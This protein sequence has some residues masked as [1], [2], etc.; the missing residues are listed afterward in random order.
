[1]TTGLDSVW[2]SVSMSTTTNKRRGLEVGREV[3]IAGVPGRF[4]VKALTETTVTCWGGRTGYEKMRTFTL[5]RIRTVHYG[6]PR[7]ARPPRIARTKAARPSKL[8]IPGGRAR[9]R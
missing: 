9:S 1:M 3:S 7:E 5:D 2:Y 4:T 6:K 8:Q